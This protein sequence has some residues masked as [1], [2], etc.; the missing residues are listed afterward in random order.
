MIEMNQVD[1]EG[2]FDVYLCDWDG[3]MNF[4]GYF[5]SIISG[6]DN[7]GAA[8][9]PDCPETDQGANGEVRRRRIAYYE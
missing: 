3:A 2:R 4:P 9:L 8:L 6:D 7:S 1:L 5:V